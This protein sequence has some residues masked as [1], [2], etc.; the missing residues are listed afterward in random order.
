[1]LTWS[2]AFSQNR[3]TNQY[4]QD[5][6][7][8]PGTNVFMAIPSGFEE[9]LVGNVYAHAET[10]AHFGATVEKKN[11]QTIV[12]YLSP[13]HFAKKDYRV[14][15]KQKFKINR[16]KAILFELETCFVDKCLSKYLLVSGTKH[17][18]CMIEAYF[19]SNAQLV[20]LAMKKAMLGMYHDIEGKYIPQQPSE[21]K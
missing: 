6:V 16:R 9:R 2:D 14:V 13:E 20:G 21:K 3:I 10:G 1:M 5:L 19:P 11:L 18:Y 4:Q 15:S 8:L 12:D 7:L 17:E